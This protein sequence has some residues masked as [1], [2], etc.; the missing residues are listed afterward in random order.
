MATYHLTARGNGRGAIYLDDGDR[1][2]FVRILTRTAE[3]YRWTCMAFCLLT[4]H[5]HLL[6]WSRAEELSA[7][8]R[9]LNSLHA[10]WFKERH[11][12]EGHAFQDRFRS[13]LIESDQHLIRTVSYIA[14]NPVRA[15]I[16]RR[17]EQWQWGSYATVMRGG[18]VLDSDRV[19]RLLDH[20]PRRARRLLQA[21][22][23]TDLAAL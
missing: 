1:A 21:V 13:R 9:R 2:D 12:R 23:E 14:L 5:Y 7:G 17:P 19:L 18:R 10:T 4:N 11:G 3:R 8:M 22:V 20:D 6:L 15:G 16:C